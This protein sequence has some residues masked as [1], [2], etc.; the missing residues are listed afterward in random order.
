MLIGA[1][2][3][4]KRVRV[5][6]G[7]DAMRLDGSRFGK[8]ARIAASLRS[9]VCFPKPMQA[10]ITNISRF[11]GGS[12]GCD[13]SFVAWMKSANLDGGVVTL[14]PY[15]MTTPPYDGATAPAAAS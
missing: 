6:R 13:F 5:R 3:A 9:L 2:S 1:L 4:R 14:L 15:L 7:H 8:L 12:R 11:P 10:V